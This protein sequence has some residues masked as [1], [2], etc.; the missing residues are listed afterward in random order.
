MS[1]DGERIARLEMQAEGHEKEIS[2][3]VSDIKAIRES[4]GKIENAVSSYRGF[5]T[6]VTF[7]IGSIAGL[8]GATLT[9]IWHKLVP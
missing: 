9:A 7:A 5:W 6:G 8:I 4:I 1:S 2:E 3:V